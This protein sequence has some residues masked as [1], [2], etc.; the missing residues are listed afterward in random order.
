MADQ[1]TVQ[2]V[3]ETVQAPPAKP[4]R[5]GRRL[6]EGARI[7]R[8]SGDWITSGTS[9]DAEI[10]SSLV[11]L[12]NRCRQLVRDND[13][14]K[15]AIRL[16]RNNVVGQGIKLQAQVPVSRSGPGGRLNKKL[17]QQVEDLWLSWGR[18][19]RCHTAG[20]L[21]WVDLQRMV[22][23]AIAES[24]EVFIRMVRQPFGDSPVPLALEVLEAD[25]CDEGYNLRPMDG[26]EWRMGIEVDGWGRPT[27][28]AFRSRHPGDLHSSG[29]TRITVVPADEILHLAMLDRPGQT[30]G[31]PWL[32]STIRRLHHL[33]GYEEAEVVRARA[34]SSLMGFIQTPEGELVGDEV[35]DGD[36]VYDFAPGTIRHLAPGESIS[37]PDLG[38]PNSEFP[39]FLRTMLQGMSAGIGISYAPL[40]QDY[41]QSNYS[42]SRLSLIDDRENW[43]VLQNYLVEA[44]CRPVYEAWM[45][46]AVAAGLLPM[47]GYEAAKDRYRK[48]RWMCRGWSW[49][50]PMK[51]VDA[52]NQAIRSG[53]TTLGQ[54]VAET[55]GDLDELLDARQQEVQQ[56][57]ELGLV[58]DSDPS[59]DAA[60]GGPSIGSGQDAPDTSDT[61]PGAESTESAGSGDA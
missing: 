59:A 16:I 2:T 20:R 47:P 5:R 35:V 4:A 26:R 22:I 57:L 46:A 41:S 44:L 38:T 7:S 6:Y 8:L 49:V 61:T 25:L 23:G 11:L 24:G 53:F 52:Y 42:S 60:T 17:N 3:Q 13:Y 48:A 18:A 15:Q 55:G 54:V 19:N 9:A 30:R 32:A 33:A 10:N 36:R 31:V 27:R 58:F 45:D 29:S 12:R 21:S 1:G 39:A 56:T 37:V 34:S 43:K 28:Y 51:E 50:D 14:A 40:S